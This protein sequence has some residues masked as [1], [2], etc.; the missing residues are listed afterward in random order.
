MTS[1]P[2]KPTLISRFGPELTVAEA[3][4]AKPKNI[5]ADTTTKL[6][7]FENLPFIDITN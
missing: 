3:A 7:Q 4:I 5:N 2:V 6:S 1:Q